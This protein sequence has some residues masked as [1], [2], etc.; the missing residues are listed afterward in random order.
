LGYQREAC[1]ESGD[2]YF[3]NCLILAKENPSKHLILALLSSGSTFCLEKNGWRI[4]FSGSISSGNQSK[5]Y[6]Q[7]DL[8]KLNIL[9]YF[10]LPYLNHVWK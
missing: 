8:A 1:F 3:K 9:L 7:G 6:P 4:L 10:W 2:L 5:D